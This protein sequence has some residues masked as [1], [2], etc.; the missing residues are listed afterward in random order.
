MPLDASLRIDCIFRIITL[1]VVNYDPQQ[2]SSFGLV[3][4]TLPV[5]PAIWMCCLVVVI[6]TI[7]TSQRV[8]T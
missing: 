3:P 1:I 5:V 7:K 6:I 8:A 4:K 2:I